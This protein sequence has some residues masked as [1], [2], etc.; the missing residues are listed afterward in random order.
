MSSPF[1][2]PPR[3]IAGKLKPCKLHVSES[4]LFKFREL[5]SLSE[6]GPETWWNTQNDPQF[7]VSHKWLTEAK[8]TWLHSFNWREHEDYLNKFPSFKVAV[9]DVEA[10]LVTIHF[11]ALFSTKED[12]IP[13]VFL[14]GF[15]ASFMEFLPMMQLLAEKYTPETLPYHII[16][17]SLP[18]YGLSGGSTRNIEMTIAQS[19]RIINQLMI[20]LGFGKGY[21]AQGGDLGSMLARV[22]S[23]DY[24]ECKAFHG[25][26]NP[27][28]R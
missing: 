4:E 6:I 18:D 1:G 15:P 13:V 7:G 21:V 25:M 9:D 28:L 26:M 24:K 10:G 23:V 3:K 16:V 5:L 27:C 19:A 17:P 2:I 11:A 8:E 20:E 12:A 14:H 22:M